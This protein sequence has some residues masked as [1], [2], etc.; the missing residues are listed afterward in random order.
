MHLLDLALLHGV[1]VELKCLKPP[2]S[3][4]HQNLK[5]RLKK[6]PNLLGL[7]LGLFLGS[8]FSNTACYSPD[9]SLRKVIHFFRSFPRSRNLKKFRSQVYK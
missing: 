2:V 9:L 5:K 7:F 8:I 1:Q 6:L 4:S 3:L